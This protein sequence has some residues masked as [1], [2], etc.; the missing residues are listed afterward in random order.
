[1][2]TIP[3]RQPLHVL[4]LPTACSATSANFYL[5]PRYETPILNVNVSL[6]MANL[7][8]INITALHFH[9]WQHMGRKHCET[10]ALTSRCPTIHTSTRGISTPSQ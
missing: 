9:V 6:N 5:P 2:E 1:M 8:A 3:I 4:K 7:Q 10:A